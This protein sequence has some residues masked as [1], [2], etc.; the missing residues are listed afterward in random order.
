M[1]HLPV[2]SLTPNFSWVRARR[3]RQETVSTVSPCSIFHFPPSIRRLF[4][5]VLYALIV[6]S[7]ATS[8]A[9][10]LFDS[11]GFEAPAYFLGLLDG[12]NGWNSVASSTEGVV[13][14]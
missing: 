3:E 13:Q 11:A 10:T 9:A 5:A 14:S 2:F 8:P 12:Q 7:A 4:H 1:K 6:L